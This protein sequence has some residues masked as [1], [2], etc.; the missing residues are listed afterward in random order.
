V[1]GIADRNPGALR[2]R[3]TIDHIEPGAAVGEWVRGAYH[4][5]ALDLEQSGQAA[6]IVGEAECYGSMN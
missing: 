1:P 3:L 4:Q 5:S 6:R 2:A